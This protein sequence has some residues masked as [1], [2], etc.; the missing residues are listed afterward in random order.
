VYFSFLSRSF[1]HFLFLFILETCP[2]TVMTTM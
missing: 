2:L 1:A